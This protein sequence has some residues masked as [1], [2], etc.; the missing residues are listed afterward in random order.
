MAG[1]ELFDLSVKGIITAAVA[2][3]SLDG[4]AKFKTFPRTLASLAWRSQGLSLSQ[5]QTAV[6]AGRDCRNGER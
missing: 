2:T 3:L 4:D 5:G 6:F 1:A